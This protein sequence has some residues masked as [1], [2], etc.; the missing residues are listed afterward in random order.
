[1][2]ALWPMPTKISFPAGIPS[3][4]RRQAEILADIV[5]LHLHREL[6]VGREMITA[7]AE[8]NDIDLAGRQVDIVSLIRHRDLEIDARSKITSAR[9]CTAVHC[10]SCARTLPFSVISRPLKVRVATSNFATPTAGKDRNM[11]ATRNGAGTFS[12]DWIARSVTWSP[13]MV[14]PERT[15]RSRAIPAVVQI[16]TNSKSVPNWSVLRYRFR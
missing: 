11:L 1:M 12:N 16:V 14:S 5:V 8:P 9:G 2:T 4:A 7:S 6:H 3:V 15:R 13:I 10:R